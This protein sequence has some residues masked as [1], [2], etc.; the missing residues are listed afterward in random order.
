MGRVFPV[1]MK[2]LC[3]HSTEGRTHAVDIANHHPKDVKKDSQM[4][5]LVIP[6]LYR[7]R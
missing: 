2:I 1:N 6:R 3:L 5:P 7:P 4:L